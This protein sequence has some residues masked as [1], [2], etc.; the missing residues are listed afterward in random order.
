[1]RK[2]SDLINLLESFK[3]VGNVDLT[4]F[5]VFFIE[6]N[7]FKRAD[8][9]DEKTLK[10]IEDAWCKSCD[11]SPDTRDMARIRI[12]AKMKLFLQILER[13]IQVLKCP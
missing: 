4:E 11:I 1:M 6:E 8:A 9:F 13:P 10:K 3:R 12:G 7:R 5:L 2:K